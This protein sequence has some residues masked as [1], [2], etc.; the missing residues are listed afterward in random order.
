MM[1]YSE[2]ALANQV[3][4]GRAGLRALVPSGND[5]AGFSRGELRYMTEDL[6]LTESDL[7]AMAAR[8][9][10][11]TTRLEGVMW[12]RDRDLDQVRHAFVMPIRDVEPVPDAK[13]SP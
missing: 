7:S 12:A 10:D 9:R 4:F 5:L 6:L 11:N 3:C 2:T 13:V 1:P 8:G